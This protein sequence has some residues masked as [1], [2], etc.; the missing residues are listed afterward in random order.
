[1]KT[2]DAR[3]LSCPEPVIL[4]RNAMSGAE[5]AYQIIVDNQ[6]ARENVTRYAV[7]QGYRV[8]VAEK[9]GEYTLS[10]TK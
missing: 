10:A 6:T 7:S 2:V 1:M 5:G 9:D 3:G 4:I 8:E